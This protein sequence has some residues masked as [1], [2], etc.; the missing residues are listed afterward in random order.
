VE[1]QVLE[2]SM[3]DCLIC[4]KETWLRGKRPKFKVKDQCDPLFRPL[5]KWY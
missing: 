2:D 4:Q 1:H 3:R 5:C